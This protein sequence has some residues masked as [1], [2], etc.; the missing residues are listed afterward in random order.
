MIGIINTIQINGTEIFRP[1]D[2]SLARENIYAAEITTC[3]GKTIAD[4]VGWKYSDM[5][6]QWDTLPQD[7]LD[8]VLA[9]SGVGT[10]TLVF[11]DIDGKHIETI[12]PTSHVYVASRT[13]RAD[14]SVVWKDISVKVEFIN[15][16]N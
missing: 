10:S 3:S 8:V 15:A 13:T 16:H 5:T 4:L 14:G 12:R 11:D 6:M 7:Q 2:F 9:M 1:D